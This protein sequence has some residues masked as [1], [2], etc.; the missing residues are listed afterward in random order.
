MTAKLCEADFLL[1]VLLTKL[2]YR[3]LIF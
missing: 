3:C 2:H 1:L